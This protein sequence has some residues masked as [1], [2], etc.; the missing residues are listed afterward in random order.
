M[1]KIGSA[2]LSALGIIVTEV[3]FLWLTGLWRIPRGLLQSTFEPSV[4]TFLVLLATATFSYCLL[5]RG[6]GVVF[7]GLVGLVTGLAIGIVAITIGAVSLPGSTDRFENSQRL[8]GTPYM[9]LNQLILAVVVGGWLLGALAF[10]IAP[11]ITGL[12]SSRSP[13]R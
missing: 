5:H 3:A 2:L 1:P 7:D 9:V 8:V 6:T 11:R 12:F 13:L 10:C 4:T